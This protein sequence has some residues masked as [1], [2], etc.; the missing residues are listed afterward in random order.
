[1]H[2]RCLAVLLLASLALGQAA[3]APSSK[4]AAKAPAAKAAAKPAT[5][6]PADNSAIAPTAAVITVH[7]VCEPPAAGAKAAAAATPK[8]DCKTVITRAQFEAMANGLQA[9]MNP[10]NK[11][12]LA[13][14]YPKMLVLAAAAKKRGLENDPQYKE[15]L[16]FA[17]LQIL[18]QVL[19]RA[20]KDDAD[21][22]PEAAIQKYFK[23]N[24]AE[25]EQADLQ[26][27][28]VPKTKQH[29]PPKEGEKTD[30]AK[31]AEI[32]KADEEAMK[33]LA[34]DLVARATA[35]EDLAK[36]QKEAFDASGQ[37][38]APPATAVGKLTRAEL[39][40]DQRV[41]LDLKAGQVSQ[42]MTEPNGFYVYKVVGKEVKPLE[43]VR[44]QIR[45]SL[46]QQRLQDAMEKIQES[47]TADLNEAYFPPQQAAPT[48]MPGR[49][50]MRPGAP[51]VAP[52]QPAP[53]AAP[54]P[55]A[56]ATAPAATP[57]QAAPATAP[58]KQ[59]EPPKETPK[60][61]AEPKN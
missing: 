10:A 8:A 35:G 58:A 51:A 24:A 14:V 39:P 18:A 54:Q 44:E 22:V 11:R 28:Y 5:S 12:R 45:A 25:F 34:D 27:L 53:S 48:G 26:R 19:T 20:V 49:P 23:D 50:P 52:R 37:K 30:A 9:N 59:P 16:K 56:P 2:A 40:V 1:M 31:L 17:R 57:Q 33:K 13:E 21:K 32:E 36:L 38:G 15:V 41:V 43:Q 42:L 29:E 46:A 55:A 47:S 4:P 61:E 3:P 60:P 6:A 7:G